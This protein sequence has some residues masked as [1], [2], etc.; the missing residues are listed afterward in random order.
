MDLSVAQRALSYRDMGPS[1]ASGNGSQKITLLS[2][3]E[4]RDNI[5]KPLFQLRFFAAFSYSTPLFFAL[6]FSGET[7]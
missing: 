3:A 2:P 7:Q 5:V 1:R 6:P 4:L